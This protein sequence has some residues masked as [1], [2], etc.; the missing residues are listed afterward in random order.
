MNPRRPAHLVDHNVLGFINRFGEVCTAAGGRSEMAR[1]EHLTP[2]SSHP[3][4]VSLQGRARRVAAG[5]HA[6][7]P[8]GRQGALDGLSRR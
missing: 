2:H 5:R 4:S 3:L 8:V 7:R 6:L 1:L